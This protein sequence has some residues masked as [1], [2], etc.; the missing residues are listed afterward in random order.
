MGYG[1]LRG[2]PFGW[3]VRRHPACDASGGRVILHRRQ[4]A[5][6]PHVSI[7]GEANG[8]CSMFSVSSF[9][10]FDRFRSRSDTMVA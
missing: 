4:D 3:R 10:F 1:L 5:C 8:Q 7:L 2:K 9:F 6:V